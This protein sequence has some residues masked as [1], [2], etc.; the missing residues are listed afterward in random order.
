MVKKILGV[1]V[2][3]VLAGL[4]SATQVKADST[5][6]VC[7]TTCST[8]GVSLI[9][10]GGSVDFDFVDVAN[11]TVTG[12]GFVVIVVPTGGGTPTL[13][14]GT[15][16][17]SK[18]FTSGDIATLLG[19]STTAYNISNFTSASAQ[20]GVT[21]TSF[22]AYEYDLGSVT[23]GPSGAGVDLSAGNLAAGS[24]IVGFVETADGTLQT[25]LSESITSGTP[26]STPEPTSSSL[27]LLGIALLALPLG[28]RKRHASVA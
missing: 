9:S 27:L 24:V 21:A 2:A 22:T 18:S 10:S 12:N 11:Q 1:A 16:E 28:L 25:P 14:G 8:G 20:V 23:L 7:D 13:T 19:E 3:V 17:E 5:Q 26:T 4:V 6:F 15:F